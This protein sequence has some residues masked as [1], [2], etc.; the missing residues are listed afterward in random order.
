MDSQL[1]TGAIARMQPQVFLQT[2]IKPLIGVI[3]KDRGLAIFAF[4]VHLTIPPHLTI[5]EPGWFEIDV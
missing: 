4:H 2:N 1:M 5:I 3:S